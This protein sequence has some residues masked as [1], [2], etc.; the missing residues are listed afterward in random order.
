MIREHHYKCSD[1]IRIFFEDVKFTISRDTGVQTPF[2][3]SVKRVVLARSVANDP[4]AH[5]GMKD[6]S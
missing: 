3:D 4:E 1:G 6:R 5:Q 2:G